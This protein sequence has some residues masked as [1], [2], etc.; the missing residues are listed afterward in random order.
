MQSPGLETKR[1]FLIATDNENMFF[2]IEKI[3]HQHI[4]NATIF[5]ATDGQEA[6]FKA[7]NVLPHVA[8]VEA[9]LQ[10]LS[11]FEVADKL[12]L[13]QKEHTVSVILLCDL[14][15]KLHFVDQVVTSQVQF[16]THKD[17]ITNLP[18]VLMRALNRISLEDSSSYKMKFLAAQ[19]VLF[20]EG[21]KA[22]SVFIVKSGELAAVKEA[23]GKK[24]ILGKIK[25]GEFVGEMAHINHENRFATVQAVSD[26]ELIEIPIGIL[27]MVLFSKP[28]WSQALIS[29]LSRRLKQS[30]TSMLNK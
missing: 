4:Q 30:T 28:A 23:H 2:S 6:L 22:E 14:P 18:P 16:I 11:G 12:I 27:D 9:D 17:V 19:E 10:K 24:V 26:C 15:D 13:K 21:D 25:P 3:I 29:T 7:S 1:I 5:A 20:S 8:I